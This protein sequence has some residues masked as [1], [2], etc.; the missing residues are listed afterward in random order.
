[1]GEI[2][3]IRWPVQALNE[4]ARSG[5][6]C[7]GLAYLSVE[8]WVCRALRQA[9]RIFR[10]QRTSFSVRGA[11]ALFG[12]DFRFSAFLQDPHWRTSAS[13]CLMSGLQPIFLA[14]ALW[15]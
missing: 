4:C 12:R 6:L 11:L 5:F 14:T 8:R 15:S 13:G 7:A 10:A 3:Q 2:L 1:M 9:G